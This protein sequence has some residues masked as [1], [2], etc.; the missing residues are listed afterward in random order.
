MILSKKKIM[1][2]P[3]RFSL[4]TRHMKIKMMFDERNRTFLYFFETQRR[5][6][7]LSPN[8]FVFFNKNIKVIFLW[9]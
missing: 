3:Q 8:S 5:N 7:Y 6:R 1:N 2:K 9:K 4:K